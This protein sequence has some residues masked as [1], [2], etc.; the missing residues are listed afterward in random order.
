MAPLDKKEKPQIKEDKISYRQE[1]VEMAI[2]EFI[3]TLLLQDRDLYSETNSVF[4]NVI[5][6]SVSP[7][8]R[9]AILFWEPARLHAKEAPISKRKIE[10]VQ[11]KL[12][13]Q[14]KWIRVMVTRHLNLKYSP[15]IQFKIRKS[16]SKSDKNRHFF[17]K[18]MK[19][20]DRI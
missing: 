4:P 6:V 13:R 14:E 9:R 8:L 12:Q 2:F 3:Q 11:N 17:E 1:R 5:D 20:L 19:W 15:I 18:E 10:G 16:M 7:D